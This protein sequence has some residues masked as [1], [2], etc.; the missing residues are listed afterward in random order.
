MFEFFFMSYAEPLFFVNYNQT[1]LWQFYVI[2]QYPVCSDQDICIAFLS[3]FDRSL[4][5]FLRPKSRKQ[6]DLCRKGSKAF[7][8]GL[9]MLVSKN[10]RRSEN[11]YLSTVHYR[12]ESR[13]HCDL[14]LSIS[15]VADDKTIHWRRRFHVFFHIGDRSCLIDRQVVG[16]RV[17]K[18]SL[19]RR[20]RWKCV[21]AN[22]LS[23][24]VQ[25]Q[26]FVGHIAHRA[27]RLCLGLLPTESA[28]SIERWSC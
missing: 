24:G 13:S 7:R 10:R 9:E 23:L 17:F 1:E 3:A 2:R 21:A 26:K 11:G 27:F 14:G 8:E 19:P 22:Q 20:I 16:K 18:F 12:L 6:I 15:D 25:T 28:K 4:L 5:F